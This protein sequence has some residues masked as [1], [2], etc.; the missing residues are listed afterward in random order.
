M[1]AEMPVQVKGRKGR[2]GEKRA[3]GP[4]DNVQTIARRREN[5]NEDQEEK[6]EKGA[7]M[8]SHASACNRGRRILGSP[9]PP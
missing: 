9:G 6:N 4:E 3:E 8:F 7:Q 1:L 5:W 2:K